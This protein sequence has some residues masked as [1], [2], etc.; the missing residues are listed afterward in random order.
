MWFG[1]VVVLLEMGW[2]KRIQPLCQSV[3]GVV[4]AQAGASVSAFLLRH[5]VTQVLRLTAS[6]P[7]FRT[8]LMNSL[9]RTMKSRTEGAAKLPR[10]AARASV[11]RSSVSV[12]PRATVRR[13]LF[14]SCSRN[15]C[16][17]GWAAPARGD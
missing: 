10:M 4:L 8:L 2:R 7:A 6:L 17:L 11:I 1:A 12:K 3:V 16:M 9:L 15:R 14:G 13:R 5:R